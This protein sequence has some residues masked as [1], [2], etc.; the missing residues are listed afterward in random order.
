MSILT[1][2]FNLF[3][4]EYTDPAAVE[5]I[6]DNMDII[7][8]ELHK[9]PLTINGVAPDGTSRDLTLNSVPLADNLTTEQAQVNDAEYVVRTSGGNSS[10][11]NGNAFLSSVKGNFV[12]EGYTAQVCTMNV[13]NATRSDPDDPG[14]SAEI[15]PDDFRD[16]VDNVTGVY[17]FVYSTAWTL[18]S[19]AVDISGYGI[20]VDGTP[21]AGDTI[22]VNFV[23]ENR[24]TIYPA[25]PESFIS[26]GW[27]LYNNATGRAR[28]C[29]YSEE[30]G[31]KVAG[32][33][34]LIEFSAT[35]TGARE[36]ITPISGAFNVPGDGWLFVSGGNNTDT[37]IWAEWSDWHEEPNGGTFEEYTESVIDLSGVMVNFPDGLMRVGGISDEINL[38]TGIAYA[39]IAKLDYD[40]YIGEVIASGQPYDTDT[41]Y[42]YVVRNAEASG[43]IPAIAV[44]DAS[45]VNGTYVADD[46]G[47]EY[48]TAT[49]VDIVSQSFYGQDLKDKLRRDVLTITPQTL[50][51]AEQ[52]AI[53]RYLGVTDAV[54]ALNALINNSLNGMFKYIEYSYAITSIASGT[55]LAIKASQFGMVAQSGYK[56][57]A[58]ALFSSGSVNLHVSYV[59]PR[60]T[61]STNAMGI[62]N[63]TSSTQSNKT[64]KIG[65][66]YVKTGY[67]I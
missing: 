45:E 37:E 7:D 23:K 8:A 26:T 61:G 32:T 16:A 30:Y 55:T 24:G 13:V 58:V 48:Y 62:R 36:Q 27:N 35:L 40:D 59:N 19:T 51:A 21:I 44:Y 60:A 53:M 22:N 46:H 52:A 18:N 66:L 9:P 14:I 33:Y 43:N 41:N 49:D 10:I 47:M 57:A 38:N 3:K 20:D 64:A 56:A 11:H 6:N 28:V 42:V 50:T 63:D 17:S 2:F 25:T 39:R 65:V 54:T 15:D 1:P 31:Y 12:K 34:L 5:K 67:G 29:R 4:P